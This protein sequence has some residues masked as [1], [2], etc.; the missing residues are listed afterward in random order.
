[1]KIPKR[2]KNCLLCYDV[3]LYNYSHAYYINKRNWVAIIKMLI[4]SHQIFFQLAMD[5]KLCVKLLP[6]SSYT[7]SF[8][9]FLFLLF[10]FI[11]ASLIAIEQSPP[12]ELTNWSF[13]CSSCWSSAGLLT[14]LTKSCVFE[15]ITS[16]I[17]Y[18]LLEAHKFRVR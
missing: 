16:C 8:F 11:P 2:H 12:V 5:V 1:M 10:T 14:R 13:L 7:D 15:T 9:W 6:S 3:I 17:T 18:F 4:L